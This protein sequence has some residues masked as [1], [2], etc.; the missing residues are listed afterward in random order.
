MLL[1]KVLAVPHEKEIIVVDDG[2]TDR[3]AAVLQEFTSTLILLRHATN[4]GKGAAI[5]TALPHATGELTLIQD[6]DLELDPGDYSKLIQ[7]IAGDSSAVFGSR[8][9]GRHNWSLNFVLNKLFSAA[10]ALLYRARVTDGMTG[11]KLI[12]T[13]LFQSLPLSAAGFAIEAEITGYLLR[14]GVIIKEVPISYSPRKK[15]QGK[16]LSYLKDSLKVLATLCKV[17][18]TPLKT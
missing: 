5:I 13:R 2:S 15:Q 10:I 12:P 4:R 14:R 8:Y 1:Q 11:Y 7:Q 17:R 18:W 6:A 3:S 16:K 9:L